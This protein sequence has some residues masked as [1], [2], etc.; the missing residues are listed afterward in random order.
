VEPCFAVDRSTRIE[1][2]GE[3]WVAYSGLA[4]HTVVLNDESAAFLEVLAERP[5]TVPEAARGLAADLGEDAARL[6]ILLRS[7]A[8]DLEALGLIV[9]TVSE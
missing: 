5:C 4:G 3:G 2:L 6:E 9:A 1:P 8:V 7:V